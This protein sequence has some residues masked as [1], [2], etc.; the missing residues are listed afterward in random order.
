[1][2]I[3]RCCAA[4]GC[5]WCDV[6]TMYHVPCTFTIARSE[7]LYVVLPPLPLLA[8]GDRVR[9]RE[10]LPGKSDIRAAK[11]QAGESSVTAKAI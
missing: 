10:R 11:Q 3:V 2:S 8:S 4:V 7:M 6:A 9:L 5:G 1:M